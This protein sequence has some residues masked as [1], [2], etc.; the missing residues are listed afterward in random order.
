MTTLSVEVDEAVEN[1]LRRKDIDTISYLA[2]LIKKDMIQ[3]QFSLNYE[4]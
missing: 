3:C 1:Y 2:D 4:Y